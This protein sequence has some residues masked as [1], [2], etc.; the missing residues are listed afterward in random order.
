MRYLALA[1]LA[2]CCV[3]Q[4]FNGFDSS[5]LDKSADP[6]GNFYQYACGGWMAANPIPADQSRW[7]RF[8]ALHERNLAILHNILET[9][10][11][12]KSTRSVTERE[13]GDYYAAC[14]DQA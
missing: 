10:S 4:K 8:N 7:G 14:M 11:A 5:S 2:T 12:D 9:E 6:C 1:L 13:I 3:G